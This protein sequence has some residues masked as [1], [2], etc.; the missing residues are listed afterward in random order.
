MSMIG[1]DLLN[2]IASQDKKLSPAAVLA[3]L[4]QGVVKKLKQDRPGSQH[5]GMEIAL[6]ALDTQQQVLHFA[7]AMSNIYVVH[8][9]QV[10]VHKGS[11][12]FIGGRLSGRV[13][14]KQVEFDD[15]EVPYQP[16]DMLYLFTDGYLDQFGGPEHQKFSA[17]RF[18]KMLA[19]IA[20]K[21]MYE[22][23]QAVHEE[24]S[25]WIGEG[26][27]QI[28]DIMVVGIKLP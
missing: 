10:Q 15:K 27:Q 18:R 24:I 4:H 17:V 1:H 8:Q 2:S 6:C 19:A 23:H 12:K 16:G 11:I 9:K 7:G 22:Q 26:G 25:E 14:G 5:D 21:N 28:D 3:A 20:E 13:Q